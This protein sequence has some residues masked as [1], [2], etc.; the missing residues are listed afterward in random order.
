MPVL[1]V[2]GT[3]D[4]KFDA[5]AR[6]M[7][8]SGAN[9]GV[10]RA[11]RRPRA[12]ARAAPRLGDC[13]RRVRTRGTAL[14]RHQSEPRA[15]RRARAG[16]APCRSARRRATADRGGAHE[17]NRARPRAARRRGASSAG[18]AST[19]HT[20]TA[21]SAPTMHSTYR[22]AG[23]G[24]ADAHRERALAGDAVGVDVA[25]VVG[26]QDRARR[27]PD[28]ERAEPRRRPGSCS[29]CTYALPTRRDEAEEHEHHHFAE[30]D[31]AVRLRAAGVGRPPR[32][33]AATPTSSSHG[34]TT[35]DSTPPTTAATRERDHRRVAHRRRR[36]EPAR[37]EPHRPAA[38]LCRCR[39][40]RRSSRSRS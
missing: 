16:S 8:A 33:I 2:T 7:S 27:E 23:A 21:T 5:I 35:S 24:R 39:A 32:T 22:A 14:V 11:R 34:F 25:H 9:A 31:V 4:A 12:A 19:P 10:V 20:T 17:P 40:H 38:V 36:R 3:R 29:C 6:A 13:S 37:D 15:A 18:G 30:P 28:R 1:L 26:E